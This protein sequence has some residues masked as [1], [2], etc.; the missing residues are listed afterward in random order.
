MICLGVGLFVF[1]LFGT[2]CASYTWIFASFSFVKFSVVTSSD[3][4]SIPF[5]LY[6]SSGI[7]T[8]CRLAHFI[9]SHRS[10]LLLSFFFSHLFV[11]VF[12]FFDWVI[13]ILS[14][15]SFILSSALFILL[16]IAFSSTFVLASELK[17]FSCLFMFLVLFYSN[18]HF[19]Q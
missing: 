6:S 5:S 17:I 16:S 11:C 9:L 1:I 19:C 10:L 7:P 8:V 13:S 3:T 15:R 12:Y 18:L 4:F 14:N 2:L